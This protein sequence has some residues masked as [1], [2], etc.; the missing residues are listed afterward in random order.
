[1]GVASRL[2][3][4]SNKRIGA[5]GL[6]VLAAS[7]S[8]TAL[9]VNGKA[10]FSRSGTVTIASGTASKTVTLAGVTAASMVVAAATQSSPVTSWGAVWKTW[11]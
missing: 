5:S 6:G 4:V 3:D 11:P 7:T 2:D 8:G 9:Q 10:K 1:M